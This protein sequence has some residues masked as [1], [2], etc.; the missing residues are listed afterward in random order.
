[1]GR[2]AQD[3]ATRFN[4]KVDRS[5]GD[6]ACWNWT[7]SRCGLRGEYGKT[8]YNQKP[9]NAHR[10]A[11]IL[12]YGPIPEGMNVLH[13]CPNGDNPLCCNPA[14]LWLG[15]QHDNMMDKAAK[16]RSNVRRGERHS[17]VKLTA[18]IVRAIRDD[19]ALGRSHR[20]IAAQYGVSQPLVT[21]I[22]KR[23]VWG[24]LD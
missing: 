1:M 19:I 24:W 17:K 20:S 18:D 8:T 10:V 2:K 7:G 9:E 23:K 3:T 12:A 22:G 11:W 14:H 13:N 21:N 5:G 15:T 4:A 6:N 16:G